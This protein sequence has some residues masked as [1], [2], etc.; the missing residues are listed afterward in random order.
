ME[1]LT[2]LMKAIS[3]NISE[4]TVVKL[5][6]DICKAL[7]LCKK[8]EIIHR[9]I[10]PQNIFISFNGDYKLGDF[11]IAKTMEKTM[12]GTKIGTYKYMAPEVYNN[13]PYGSSADIYSLGLVLYW[14]LNDRRMPFLPL[15]PAKL[16]AGMEEEARQRRL[17]GETLPAPVHGSVELKRIVLKACAFDQKK[18]YSSAA[19]MLEDLNALTKKTPAVAVPFNPVK[20][21]HT[22]T[23]QVEP[24]ATAGFCIACGAPLEKGKNFCR[25]CGRPVNAAIKTEQPEDMTATIGPVFV[26]KNGLKQQNDRPALQKPVTLKKEQKQGNG[27]ITKKVVLTVALAIAYLLIVLL[28][29]SCVEMGISTF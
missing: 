6:K 13:Q 11:G 1:L 15:P 28:M 16:K 29:R 3:A 9:D 26:T 17:M 14:L 27:K 22:V 4:E 24:A 18:R 25:M 8:H 7:V 19:Q 5:G 23:P 21:T 20:E 2:P 10:K 12:G